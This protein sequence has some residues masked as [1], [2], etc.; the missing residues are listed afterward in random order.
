M[1]KR[2]APFVLLLV[3]V[4]VLTLAKELV[5]VTMSLAHLDSYLPLWFL[6]YAPYVTLA[7]LVLP[8]VSWLFVKLIRANTIAFG[9][10]CSLL[11]LALPLGYLLNDSSPDNAFL[12]SANICLAFSF[13]FWTAVFARF[14]KT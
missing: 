4:L 13:A 3:F 8:L 6:P 5:M 14:R 11:F 7:F 1:L 9:L 12:I 10:A 2:V